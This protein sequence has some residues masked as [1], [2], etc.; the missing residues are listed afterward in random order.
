MAEQLVRKITTNGAF[1]GFPEDR[2]ETGALQINDDWPGLFIRGDACMKIGVTLRY[3]KDLLSKTPAPH[4]DELLNHMMAIVQVD[5]LLAI[6]E[7]DV[8]VKPKEKT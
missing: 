7:E 5:T 6:I 3:I 1:M 2:V 4:K 8:F